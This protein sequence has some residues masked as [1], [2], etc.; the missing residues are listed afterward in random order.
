MAATPAPPADPDIGYGVIASAMSSDRDLS[1]FRRFGTLN[2][3]NLLYMQ[4][5]LAALEEKLKATD[6]R[7][8]SSQAQWSLP[9]SWYY[10][11]KDN[12]EYLALVM[13]IRE[14]LAAY[15]MRRE[16]RLL[17]IQNARSDY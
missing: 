16:L 3:R 12:G 7:C 4:S 8:I 10:L 6:I 5:E 17:S 13:E 2:T 14:K 1:M 15:S 9:R 11:E